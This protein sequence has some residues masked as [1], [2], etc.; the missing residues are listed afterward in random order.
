MNLQQA[1]ALFFAQYLGQTWSTYDHQQNIIAEGKV[2][3][4]LSPQQIKQSVVLLRTVDQLTDQESETIRL[5][6]NFSRFDGSGKN[7]AKSLLN[8][9]DKQNQ[10][11]AIKC[12]QYLLRIG[13]LLPFTYLNEQNQRI[14]L[15]PNEIIELGWAKTTLTAAN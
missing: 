14:T 3:W 11:E 1:K 13:I 10:Q 7:F 12:Y 15:Q 5:I 2:F 4:L 8:G 9:L 6:F